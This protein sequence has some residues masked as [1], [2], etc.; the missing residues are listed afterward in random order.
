MQKHG[1]TLGAMGS[2]SFLFETKG[3][4]K[5]KA[6]SAARDNDE[7]EIIDAGAQDLEDAAR[8]GEDAASHGEGVPGF[9][10]YTAPSEFGAVRAALE[11][12]GFTVESGELTK[13][14]KN[15]VAVT[16]REVAQKILTLIEL[17]EE[18]DDIINIAANFDIPEELLSS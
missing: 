4:L 5:V 2:T 3:M 7:L 15:T 12:K 14:P 13:I 10:V 6:R 16:D 18:D 1:G 9:I 17:I 8:T 11:K